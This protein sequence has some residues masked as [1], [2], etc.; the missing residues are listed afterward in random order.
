MATDLLSGFVWEQL[1]DLVDGATRR[2]VAVSRIGKKAARHMPVEAGDVLLFDGSRAALERGDV[3]PDA[4][5]QLAATGATVLSV[6]GLHATALLLFA[7]GRWL[8]ATGSPSLGRS[9]TQSVQDTLVVTDEDAVV[10]ALSER[11]AVWEVTGTA[12]DASWLKSARK[13][14]RKPRGQHGE[15]GR[16]SV[17]AVKAKR[18]LWIH[19]GSAVQPSRSGILQRAAA[20][21][22]ALLGEGTEISTW[23]VDAAEGFAPAIGDTLLLARDARGKDPA[24]LGP[25]ARVRLTR[26]L[27]TFP[28]G[29]STRLVVLERAADAENRQTLS[30][31]R[32]TVT[33][34]GSDGDAATAVRSDGDAATAVRSD[35]DAAQDLWGRRIEDKSVR[36][37]LIALFR[38]D[39]D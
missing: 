19:H 17:A 36:K 18:D 29:T 22:G 1:T 30:R 21:S 38:P 35:G 37:E 27:G 23:A 8:A 31:I 11:F 34:A 25:G 9:A 14:A 26:V 6:E 13:H 5:E 39:P 10:H 2:R 20:D 3:D 15:F 33:G 12:V 4:V 28:T 16:P 32:R 24:A 7:G